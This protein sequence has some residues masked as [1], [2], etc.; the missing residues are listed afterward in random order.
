MRKSEAQII[1]DYAINAV[2]KA[3]AI[4]ENSPEADSVLSTFYDKKLY[5][6][7]TGN[8]TFEIGFDYFYDPIEIIEKKYEIPEIAKC[9]IKD[10]KIEH[11]VNTTIT[12]N[13][14][15]SATFK[16]NGDTVYTA[17]RTEGYDLGKLTARPAFAGIKANNGW[18]G[19]DAVAV[20]SMPAA[21][22]ELAKIN[23]ATFTT[24]LA[25]GTHVEDFVIPFTELS[26]TDEL[27]KAPTNIDKEHYT[28]AWES[29]TVKN[30][31]LTVLGTYTPIEYKVTFKG[32]NYEETF[33][34]TVENKDSFK[35]PTVPVKEHYDGSWP[36]FELDFSEDLV[37]KAEYTKTK[38]SIIFMA[39]GK[40]VQ[41]VDY[42]YGDTIELPEDPEAE[43][44]YTFS[45]WGSFQLEYKKDQIVNAEF[46]P[47]GTE[48][49]YITF[50]DRNSA[51]KGQI[52]Y[53]KGDGEIYDKA[54]FS[55]KLPAVP[56]ERGYNVSWPDFTKELFDENGILVNYKD[57]NVTAHY[58]AITYTA[59]FHYKNPETSAEGTIPLDYT[60]E[61]I[62]NGTI[63]IPG[64][65]AKAT[66]KGYTTKWD[67]DNINNLPLD[68][69]T[70]ELVYT[71][72][73][74]EIQFVDNNNTYTYYFTIKDTS[75]V[76]PPEKPCAKR[77]YENEAW[78]KYEIF[79]EEIFENT[80]RYDQT[81]EAVYTPT[82]YYIT[83][84][85]EEG[86]EYGEKIPF[87]KDMTEEQLAAIKAPYKLPVKVGYKVS[88]PT[89][90][91][92]F[93]DG[94]YD[95]TNTYSFKVEAIYETISYTTNFLY[96]DKD[97]ND[98]S[99]TF[100]YTIDDEGNLDLPAIPSHL[101][102]RGYTAEWDFDGWFPAY[103]EPAVAY[104]RLRSISASPEMT[105]DVTIKYTPIPY[106][107]TFV[108]E[109]GNQIGNKI[110]FNMK[111]NLEGSINLNAIRPDAPT[112]LHYNVFW[113]DLDGVLLYDET[114]YEANGNS[115]S[116]TVTAQYT[117]KKYSVTFK[118]WNGNDYG[119][120]IEFTIENYASISPSLPNI[121]KP[122]YNRAWSLT[123][124]QIKN[125][126]TGFDWEQDNDPSFT[127]TA[128]SSLISYTATFKVDGN[129]VATI[130]FNVETTSIEAPSIT[131][132]NGYT[133]KWDDYTIVAGNIEITAIYTP[134]IYT[135][136]FKIN[137]Q[138]VKEVTFTVEDEVLDEPF[139]PN[140]P[141]YTAAWSSYS[142]LDATDLEI[143][144]IYTIITYKVTFKADG[145]VIA[146]QTYTVENKVIT[147]PSVPTKDGFT[148]A[149][150]SYVLET[151]DVTV[152]AVYTKIPVVETYYLTITDGE[153]NVIVI[154]FDANTSISDITL[155]EL[156]KKAGYKV[157]WPEFSLF[158]EDLFNQTGSYNATISPIYELI[159]YTATFKVNGQIVANL[160]FN[161]ETEALTLPAI[162]EVPGYTAAWS[163]HTIGANDMIIEAVYTPITY[164]VTFMA[165]GKEVAVLYYT[166]EN[167][168][169]EEPAVPEKDGFTGKWESY[170][171]DIGDKVVNAVYTAEDTIDDVVPGDDN[172][173]KESRIFWG[174]SLIPLV[175]SGIAIGVIYLVDVKKFFR[176]K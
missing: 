135:A 142:T 126:I 138:V 76:T 87:H 95:S 50:Y 160:P 148:G 38:Y 145:K 100:Y 65:P 79:N 5:E 18:G 164:S 41:T 167:L 39:N 171:L 129:T 83:F 1:L 51:F 28:L 174:I 108:D 154:P 44:G 90:F 152:N 34:Y 23:L 42:Y 136:T 37:V 71:L 13:G 7:Y 103:S 161:V 75:T 170:T 168:S 163:E 175:A 66:Q 21:D 22:V 78:A 99:F 125:Q 113:P 24:K 118:D 8:G 30:E 35:A 70:V 132:K 117:P 123:A 121:A 45:G 54:Y 46:D 33:I 47:I 40:V 48:T 36:E 172:S 58:E 68:S 157:S 159:Q 146:T 85:D 119:E 82:V 151:G 158:D 73:K 144:A 72:I 166:V 60:I 14:L 19:A 109:S 11:R 27:V 61:D 88:W 43:E 140:K 80:G 55:S 115:Y 133:A 93:N 101:E 162:P 3:D 134:I 116:F 10:S 62:Q 156:P 131:P 107:I 29:F 120:P 15:Y 57:L 17:F 141:G 2:N 64:I 114:R 105:I 165:D 81:V 127:V 84:V 63:S 137:G 98:Q 169:I 124:D 147:E 49:Y 56:T 25:N 12:F 122:G 6:F 89:A 77:G 139:L 96:V 92:F 16:H 20:A 176:A 110:E 143:N 111:D 86:H 173:L 26:D 130:P 94:R 128:T 59:S 97:G 112:K 106:Y 67:I 4:L 150:E 104:Y 91:D 153:G 32:E 69:I 53:K 149:W 155:P 52:S 31:D 74:Y 102:R 9:Y